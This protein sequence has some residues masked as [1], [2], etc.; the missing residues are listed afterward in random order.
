V[1]GKTI[2]YGDVDGNGADFAI[3]LML[4]VSMVGSDFFL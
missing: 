4:P 1:N 3:E 2:I